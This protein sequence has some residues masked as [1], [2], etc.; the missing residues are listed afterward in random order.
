MSEKEKKPQSEK[1]KKVELIRGID[2]YFD[3]N[4]HWVFTAKYL[5][6]RGFCCGNRCKHC[7]Y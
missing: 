1:K 3:G 5:S 7:P 6:D 2:Y 4:G